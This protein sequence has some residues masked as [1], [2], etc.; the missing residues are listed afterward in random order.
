MRGSGV[1]DGSY[2]NLRSEKVMDSSLSNEDS[3][4]SVSVF[5]TYCILD[6]SLLLHL[7]AA[8]FGDLSPIGPFLPALGDCFLA[9][10]IFH[11]GDFLGDF[12]K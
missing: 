11:S 6:S 8:R 4:N 5:V 1:K 12:L 3:T 7:S 10:T 2:Q 9:L